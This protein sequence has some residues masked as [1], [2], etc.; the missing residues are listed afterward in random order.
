MKTLFLPIYLQIAVLTY[1]TEENLRS[2]TSNVWCIL[3]QII[4]SVAKMH[5]IAPVSLKRSLIIVIFC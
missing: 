5:P 3:I 1:S 2:G 4:T